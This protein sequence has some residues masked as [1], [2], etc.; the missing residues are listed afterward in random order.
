MAEQY[1]LSSA[2]SRTFGDLIGRVLGEL[3]RPDLQDKAPDFIRDAIRY[4]SRQPFFFNE[5]DNATVPAWTASLYV[6][7]GTTIR[8]TASDGNYYIFVNLVSGSN[9][10]SKPTF[11]PNLFVPSGSAGIVFTA[12]QTGTTVD[13]NITWATV[14]AWPATNAAANTFWT[15]LSTIPSTNQYTP[16]IDYISPRR[17]EITAA[18]LR[19]P[20]GKLSYDELRNLDVIR[21]APIT[22]YPTLW[23]W[24]QNL[25]YV[26][27]YSLGFYPLTL[28]YYTGPFPPK[29]TNESNFWTTTAEAMIRNC[30]KGLLNEQIIRDTEAMAKDFAA[31]KREFDALRLQEVEMN[32]TGKIP[33][34]SW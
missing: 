5:I 32:A 10:G 28:S 6:P 3:K 14:Q 24:Y 19:L 31:A 27:P 16:P 22:V 26:W 30:A 21:P 8:D 7:A 23:A 2:D 15:Q 18:G 9:G 33:P 34:D 12:G 4:Y 11:T 13:G 1:V 20:L 29:Q 25:I 17:V